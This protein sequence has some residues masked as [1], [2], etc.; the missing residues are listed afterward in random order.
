MF[1]MPTFNQVAAAREM[2]FDERPLGVIL[3]QQRFYKTLHE[4]QKNYLHESNA[5]SPPGDAVPQFA[6]RS[7]PGPQEWH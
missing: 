2:P 3:D 6:R 7:G 5:L 4:R 1:A